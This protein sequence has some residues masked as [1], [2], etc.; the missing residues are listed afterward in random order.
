[1]R[2]LLPVIV[3]LLTLPLAACGGDDTAPDDGS[4]A[5]VAAF[6]PLAFVAERVGGDA[7]SVTNLTQPGTEPHDLE[8]VPQDVGKLSDSD[9][10]VYLSGFQPAVDDAIETAQPAAT[11]D[12]RETADLSLT[13]EPIG[14]EAAGDSTVDP[15][16]WLDPLRLADVSDALADE[17]STLSPDD[18]PLFQDNAAQLRADLEALDQKMRQVLSGC[19]NTDVVTTHNAFGYLADAFELTQVGIS[20]LS[21]DN[22]P[23]PGQLTAI[24][25]F[26]EQNDVKTIY[27]ET[28]VSPAIAETIARST[29][30]RLGV[31]DPIEG[32]ADAGSDDD[33][34]DLMLG[35]LAQLKEGQPC[36]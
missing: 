1:V 21:P 30:S 32:L 9:L 3:A 10:A 28:L 11:F 17:L 14:D 22:E 24:A 23:T 6:Y 4:L 18:A 35:N 15:H 33:Y 31:L 5:V 16:F 19:T 26:V 29:G 34:F 25:D 36:P 7:V 27:Y 12:A 8:L 20:G 2:L 13:Y